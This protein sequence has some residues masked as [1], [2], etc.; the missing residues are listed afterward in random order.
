MKY[1]GYV[2]ITDKEWALLT[3]PASFAPEIGVYNTQACEFLSRQIAAKT[4]D[5]AYLSVIPKLINSDNSVVSEKKVRHLVQ[6]KNPETIV[7]GM[8]YYLSRYDSGWA[9]DDLW[10]PTVSM[11]LDP[12]HK[13]KRVVMPIGVITP[14]KETCGLA[15]CLDADKK[16]NRF[17]IIGLQQYPGREKT[18]LNH[19]REIR[20][21]L[22][23]LRFDIRNRY[24]V[25]MSIY[26]N[27]E[28]IC[29]REGVAGPVLGEMCRL[30]VQSENPASLA[31]T[32]VPKLTDKDVDKIHA[33]NY[34]SY[35]KSAVYYR[36]R[37]R[38]N[39]GR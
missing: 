3:A 37:K 5:V 26:L 35:R 2:A 6:R 27:K 23:G 1:I 19:D 34:Q 33:E 28:P 17:D 32:A 18:T 30:L 36:T 22:V 15:L 9:F 13:L 12:T 29:T 25:K 14:G 8:V 39:D 10:V 7:A 31:T 16:Q 20:K 4:P 38:E 24:G 21:L 11:L